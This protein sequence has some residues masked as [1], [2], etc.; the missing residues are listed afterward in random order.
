LD[1]FHSIRR[2]APFFLPSHP[3]PPLCSCPSAQKG[4]GKNVKLL[5]D[6]VSKA[7]KQPLGLLLQARVVNMPLEII[8]VLHNVTLRAC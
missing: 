7:D 1:P 2:H 8:P 6:L 4:S 3:S 5:D